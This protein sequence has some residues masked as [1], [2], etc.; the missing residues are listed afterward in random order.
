MQL[1]PLED[2]V[3]VEPQGAEEKTSGGI[4]L[5][6]SAKEKPLMGKVTAVGPG[7]LMD[8]GSRADMGVKIGDTVIYSQYGGSDFK[9]DGKE[10]KILRESDILGIVE[11]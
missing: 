2:R 11:K 7:K 4:F 3:I 10:I 9:L 5:P 1:R 8:N 6:E